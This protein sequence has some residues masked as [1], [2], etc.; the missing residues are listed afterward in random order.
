VK[1]TLV[2]L[3]CIMASVVFCQAKDEVIPE[4][5]HSFSKG[6]GIDQLGL[7]NGYVEDNY[8]AAGGLISDGNGFYIIDHLNSRILVL[9]NQFEYRR[10]IKQNN[11]IP[12]GKIWFESNLIVGGLAGEP[13]E[14]NNTFYIN[15]SVDESTLIL[16]RLSQFLKN[17]DRFEY[18]CHIGKT[19]LF[20]DESGKYFGIDISGAEEGKEATLISNEKLEKVL[21]AKTDRYY[22]N[23]DYFMDREQL[24]ARAIP[25]V[26]EYM[27]G[28]SNFDSKTYSF[29]ENCSYSP[30][31]NGR[32]L[33]AASREFFIFDT[34]GKILQDIAIKN[35]NIYNRS[36][37]FSPAP[38]GFIYYLHPDFD[39]K[40]TLVYRLGPYPELMLGYGGTGGTINDDNVNVREQA[41]TKSVVVARINKGMPARILDKTA[42]PETIGGKTAVWYQVRLWD[43]TEGWVF[44]AFLDIGG[45]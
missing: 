45:K 12:V 4:I 37:D 9:T 35:K 17:Y 3:F 8:Y 23:G 34:D 36:S 31:P 33:F 18:L 16:V 25:T 19:L 30:L 32:F 13:N 26:L 27:A 20:Q 14:F 41:N 24:L 21:T 7:L 28:L 15:R 2:F 40:Q 22:L 39:N 6:D 11:Y 10:E 42:T 43:R 5:A 38:D 44:G 1:K 29:L